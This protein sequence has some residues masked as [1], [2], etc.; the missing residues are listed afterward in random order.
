ML[1]QA[2]GSG[3]AQSALVHLQPMLDLLPAGA[4]VCD[5]R[6][7]ITHCTAKAVALWGCQPDDDGCG[8][9]WSGAMQMFDEDGRPIPHN[10]SPLARAVSDGVPHHGRRVQF[11][12]PDGSRRHA[13]CYASPLLDANGD[14]V[15]GLDLMVDI[16]EQHRAAQAERDRVRAQGEQLVAL[17]CEIRASLTPLRRQDREPDAPAIDDQLRHIT[18]LVDRVLNLEVDAD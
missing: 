10:A 17:A 3:A 6:G 7:R 4:C 11:E 18:R 16:T 13:L 5:A 8:P 15:G 14:V 1:M 12:R 9:R 2:G